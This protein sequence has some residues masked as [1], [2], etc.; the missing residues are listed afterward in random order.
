MTLSATEISKEKYLELVM[1]A[2]MEGRSVQNGRAFLYKFN[3]GEFQIFYECRKRPIWAMYKIHKGNEITKD[4]RYFKS[5]QPR[6]GCGLKNK[7]AYSPYYQNNRIIYY[8]PAPLISPEVM[9]NNEGVMIAKSMLNIAPQSI[10]LGFSG[11]GYA[12]DMERCIKRTGGELLV[13]TGTVESDK[14]NNIQKE[15]LTP[16]YIYK[17]LI[18]GGSAGFEYQSWLFPNDDTLVT[19]IVNDYMVSIE[20]I[21]SISR[22]PLPQEVG[23]YIT[24][25]NQKTIPEPWLDVWHECGESVRF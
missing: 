21:M 17:I 20:K 13:I 19:S 12:E 16:D 14:R 8:K 3:A 23:M 11:I 4:M 25:S 10:I 6:D 18:R 15:G 24:K 2:R 7:S 9:S 22:W 5:Y 1:K